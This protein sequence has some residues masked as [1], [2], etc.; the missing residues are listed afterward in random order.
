MST[1]PTYAAAQI[2]TMKGMG[3]APGPVTTLRK[4]QLSPGSP[5][6]PDQVSRPLEYTSWYA[7][8]AE[9][10]PG[11]QGPAPVPVK[12]PTLCHRSGISTQGIAPAP[13]SVQQL[14]QRYQWPR[15]RPDC[16]RAPQPKKS[17]HHLHPLRQLHQSTAMCIEVLSRGD[18]GPQKNHHQQVIGHPPPHAAARH[19]LHRRRTDP[20]PRVYTAPTR[21][22]CC[23]QPVHTGPYSAAKAVAVGAGP[24]PIEATLRTRPWPVPAADPASGASRR[25]PPTVRSH[26]EAAAT[27]PAAH[28]RNQKGPG[29]VRSVRQQ[30]P[31]TEGPREALECLAGSLPPRSTRGSRS[32]QSAPA[33]KNSTLP[34]GD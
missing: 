28:W 17:K 9:P 1:V 12:Q 6:L 27:T 26:S 3:G 20:P 5:R 31:P 29:T 2:S 33:K 10:I 32:P 22:H 19:H 24:A 25:P 13:S 11:N 4:S 18:S 30:A 21:F 14:P 16:R 8:P 15:D 7:S 34:E 23:C